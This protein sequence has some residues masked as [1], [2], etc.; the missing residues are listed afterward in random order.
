MNTEAPGID[1]TA[2]DEQLQRSQQHIDEAKSA[3]RDALEDTESGTDADFP[4][5]GQGPG[6]EDDAIPRPN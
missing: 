4:D 2:G 5:A 1:D 3:A 6:S